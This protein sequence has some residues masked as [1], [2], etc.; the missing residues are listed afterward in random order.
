MDKLVLRR[1]ARAYG[2]RIDMIMGKAKSKRGLGK[3][4]GGGLSAAE[5]KY[6]IAHEWAKSADDILWRRTKCGLHMS[7]AEQKAFTKWFKENA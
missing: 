4:F 1:M 7:E 3:S 2:T 6:L 5:V